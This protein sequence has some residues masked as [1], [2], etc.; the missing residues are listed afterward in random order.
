MAQETIDYEK[1]ANTRAELMKVEQNSEAIRVQATE[2]PLTEDDLAGVIELWTGI[3][4]SK[5]RENELARLGGAGGPS[6]GK[7]YRSG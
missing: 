7:N 6:P 1:L 3:P 4:A 5:V 2:N